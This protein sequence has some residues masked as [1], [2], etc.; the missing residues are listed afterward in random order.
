MKRVWLAF[1]L[2]CVA[3][4]LPLIIPFLAAAGLTGAGAY[5]AGLNWAEIA[6]LAVIGGAFV[7]IAILV[8]R[9]RRADGPSCEVRE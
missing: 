3:C 4:C 2:A 7:A 8:L 9:R 1:G 5:V 6:C